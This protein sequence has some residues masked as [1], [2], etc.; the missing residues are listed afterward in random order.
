MMHSSIIT[1]TFFGSSQIADDGDRDGPEVLV[2][3][4][5]NH[6][7]QLLA[8]EYLIETSRSFLAGDVHCERCENVLD[9]PGSVLSAGS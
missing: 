6:L 7:V 5:F 4:P 9:L 1:R 8:Q 3:Q 2:Y